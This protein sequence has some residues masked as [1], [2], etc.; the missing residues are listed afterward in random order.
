MISTKKINN[1]FEDYLQTYYK[2]SLK[3]MCKK[4]MWI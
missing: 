3:I 1:M 2:N 4:N